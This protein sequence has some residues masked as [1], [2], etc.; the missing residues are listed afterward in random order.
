MPWVEHIG[1]GASTAT[2]TPD[3]L[4]G[5]TPTGGKKATCTSPASPAPA[6]PVVLK[7][8]DNVVVAYGED[9]SFPTL[10]DASALEKA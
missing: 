9:G 6:G 4:G 2:V 8:K 10:P 5:D 3:R 7:D 1:A